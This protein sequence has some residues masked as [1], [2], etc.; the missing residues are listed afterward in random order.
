MPTALTNIKIDG[1]WFDAGDDLSD[2]TDEQLDDLRAVGAVVED[3]EDN[4]MD[5][6]Q[7]IIQGSSAANLQLEDDEDEIVHLDDD[8]E[9]DPEVP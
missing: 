3:D 1:E 8:E 2:L 5:A 4:P 7:P 6:P 9:D